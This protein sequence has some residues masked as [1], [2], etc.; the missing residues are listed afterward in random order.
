MTAREVNT[1]VEELFVEI[2]EAII[3]R[4]EVFSDD[5]GGWGTRPKPP[6]GDGWHI[7]DNSNEKSTRWER[8]RLVSR[9][10]Q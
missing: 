9:G 3:T 4:D 1:S 2:V 5:D 6:P 10:Q 7:A 8:T